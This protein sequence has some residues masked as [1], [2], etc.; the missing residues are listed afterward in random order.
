MS[1]ASVVLKLEEGQI[2]PPEGVTGSRN[3]HGGNSIY[4]KKN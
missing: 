2:D 4:R 3:S 1:L